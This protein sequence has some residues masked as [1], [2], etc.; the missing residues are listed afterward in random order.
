MA[1]A[2]PAT[3]ANA[4]FLTGT[5]QGTFV[6]HKFAQAIG[7]ETYTIE[8]SG[9]GLKLV[10]EFLFTDRGSPVPLK[11]VY[12]ENLHHE[13][14]TLTL[15]GKSSRMSALKDTFS[16]SA[17]AHTLTREHDGKSSTVP[18]APDTF[19]IDG[20]SPVAMQQMLMRFW[21]A[22]GKPSTIPTPSGEVHI[23]PAGDLTIGGKV[24]HGYVLDGLIWG[25]ETLWVDD[26]QLLIALVSTDAE[27]DHFEAVRESSES[28][29]ATFISAA[30][31]D[32]LAALARLSGSSRVP[33]A[34]RLYIT[35]ITLIDGTGAPA[36]TQSN[37]LIEAGRIVSIDHKKRANTKD[38]EILDGTGKFLI[39]G[40]WDMHAHYEQVEWGPIYL[41]AGVTTVRDCGNEFDFITT[42]RDTLESGKGIGPRVLIAGIVDGISK[43]SL[44]AVT[45]DTPEQA[46]AVVRRYKA[47][48]ASQIKIYSSMKPELVPVIAAETHRLGMTLTGHVPNGMTSVQAVEAGYDGINHVQF[49]LGDLLP[50]KS[51]RKDP[52]PVV[53]FTTDSAKAQLAVYKKHSTVLDDTVS[54]YE[55]LYR[56]DTIKLESFEPGIAHVA[57]QLA[58]ALANPG[59]PPEASR[60]ANLLPDMY[61]VIRW[62]HAAGL[63]VVAGTDQNIPGYS[64]HRELELYV[65]KAGF[66]P[67]EALQA[68]TIVPARVMA[69]DKELGTIEPGKRA[70]L[71]LL[72]ADPLADIH[73]TRR[74]YKTI[75]Q[76]KVYDPAPLWRSVDFKP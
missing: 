28:S 65:E 70:D 19:L 27:F 67:M 25:G 47:A 58:E 48:G 5:E 14:L 60:L 11:T 68:A 36:S 29:L 64:L 13:P 21:L 73:N 22:H 33:Q 9:S 49:P 52:V 66:T 38:A 26:Q 3:P 30:A 18:A 15:D 62:W 61:A 39:P 41:A 63:P 2:Q 56:P 10:S 6:L 32:Q 1:D 71:V 74:V 23:H 20:Y 35:N 57:P 7:K 55:V 16:L 40:L 69:L 24:L 59:L 72:D 17:T 43:T 76:G 31:R 46:I 45:A 37:V 42:V 34:K 8:P 44:G 54:L 50:P 75:E 53:D 4:E 51:G 12:T